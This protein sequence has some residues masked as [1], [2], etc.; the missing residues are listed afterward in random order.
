MIFLP[1]LSNFGQKKMYNKKFTPIVSE[2]TLV[3]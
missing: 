2:T 3:F 1:F